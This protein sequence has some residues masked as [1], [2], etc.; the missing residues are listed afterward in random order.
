MSKEILQQAL[1]LTQQNNFPAAIETL[2]PLL[3]A[4]EHDD[5]YYRA[6]KLYADIIGPISG[7]DH[8][9][10]IDIYQQIINGAESDELYN[11][12]QVAI[13]KSNLM[14]AF[15]HMEAF[16]NTIDIIEVSDHDKH[17]IDDLVQKREAFITKRAENIYKQRL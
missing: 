2:K 15:Y 10:A 4:E 14:L 1:D 5:N 6:L 16:E 12:A 13:L 17:F 9:M 8:A 3:E 11:S 7:N